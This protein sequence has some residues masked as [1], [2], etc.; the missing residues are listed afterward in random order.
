[1]QLHH[2]FLVFM[3]LERCKLSASVTV[4]KSGI[5]NLN[6]AIGG[7]ESGVQDKVSQANS[8]RTRMCV[9]L[10]CGS[11]CVLNIYRLALWQL[12]GARASGVAWA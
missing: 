12:H 1:M 9:R 10:M 3:H 7:A 4:C 5:F 6:T 2:G 11:V 8:S